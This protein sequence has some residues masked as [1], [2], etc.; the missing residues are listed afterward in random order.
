MN[1]TKSVCNVPGTLEVPGTSMQIMSVNYALVSVAKQRF[2]T[3]RREA[4][5]ETPVRPLRSLR[6]CVKR[7]RVSQQ[8]LP[9]CQRLK[10]ACNC[11][12]LTP[13]YLQCK[14]QKGGVFHERHP[15]LPNATTIRRTID[16]RNTPADDAIVCMP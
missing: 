1:L 13:S 14:S 2:L 11:D 7:F 5:Q 6:L 15:L 4:R 10:S 8:E 9:N 12:K 3:P 16:S